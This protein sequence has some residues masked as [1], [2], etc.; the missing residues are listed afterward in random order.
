M[1][2]CSRPLYNVNKPNR[3]GRLRRGSFE[4]DRG[5]GDGTA[6]CWL[7]SEAVLFCANSD[8]RV[9]LSLGVTVA[10]FWRFDASDTC[11]TSR[12]FREKSLP[13]VECLWRC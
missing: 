13:K 4:R 12:F 8:D 1:G 3:S 10:V 11:E 6:S 9:M 2:G 7:A 5:I